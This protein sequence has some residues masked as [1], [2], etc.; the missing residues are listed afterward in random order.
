MFFKY[1]LQ[2]TLTIT[3]FVLFSIKNDFIINI[4]GSLLTLDFYENW[5]SIPDEGTLAGKINA[6]QS[7]LQQ[8]PEP[9]FIL[10]KHLICVLVIIKDSSM[11]NLDS[12]RLSL[13]IAPHVLWGQTSRDSLF[14]S[15]VL[16]KMSLIQIMIDNYDQIFG[17]DDIF[18][19]HI[20][21]RSEDL[22]TYKES[23]NY[24][25]KSPIMTK[26]IAGHNW[27]TNDID[28]KLNISYAAL[29]EEGPT[30]KQKGYI[31]IPSHQFIL[32]QH[33]QER[34]AY[35]AKILQAFMSTE[36][37]LLQNLICYP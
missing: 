28:E 14:G 33:H 23:I 19:K 1:F 21:K 34:N 16:R 20:D 10:L 18:S 31:Y 26:A 4:D 30:E 35:L 2:C 3:F 15:D 36:S 9:N 27:K 11:N 7:L 29:Q 8:I 25:G 24:S 22:K 13:R 37:C 32:I 6:I 17:N 12:Y 5:L